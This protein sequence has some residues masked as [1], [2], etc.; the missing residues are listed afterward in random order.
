[1]TD[2]ARRE[3]LRVD[4]LYGGATQT[5]NWKADLPYCDCEVLID[6]TYFMPLGDKS[7]SDETL[8]EFEY[9]VD[10]RADATR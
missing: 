3:V 5:P 1:M 10:V 2:G 8:I 6:R 7:W 4:R 9:M